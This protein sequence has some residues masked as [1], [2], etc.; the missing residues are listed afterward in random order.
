MRGGR[1]ATC[2]GHAFAGED[3]LRGRLIEMLLCDFAIDHARAAAET[4]TTPAAV[5]ALTRPLRDGFGG[6][7]EEEADR[8]S[9][10]PEA[11]PLARIIAHRL[12]AY[13]PAPGAHSSAI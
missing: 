6:L 10:R 12:D 5:R 7:L 3:R 4:G 8:L 1:L 9:I 2:R 13:A 11:R